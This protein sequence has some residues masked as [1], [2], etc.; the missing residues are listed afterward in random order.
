MTLTQAGDAAFVETPDL[1]DLIGHEAAW[2]DL[3]ARAA[4]PNVF[5][6]PDFLLPALARL[7][8]RGLAIVFVWS[9]AMRARL[10]GLGAIERP[11]LSLGLARV[12]RSEQAALAALLV[13]RE[14]AEDALAALLAWTAARGAAGLRLPFL[15]TEGPTAQAAA[16]LAARRSLPLVTLETRRRAVLRAGEGAD[17]AAGLDKR[18]RKEWARQRRRL[19]ER[20]R[21]ETRSLGAAA[22]AEAFLAVENRGWKGARGTALARV[23]AH[24]AFANDMLARFAAQGALRAVA[25]ML[26]DAPIAVGLALRTGARG[27][28]W[29]TAYDE[30]F[31]EYSPGLLLTLDLSRSL[32]RE[33][34]LTLVDSCAAPNHPMID[35]LWRARLELADFA[36]AVRPETAGR[37][38][39]ALAAGWLRERARARLKAVFNRFLRRKAS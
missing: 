31:A 9:D 36:L 39:R 38:A 18:R 30:R 12:W 6:E 37:F 5:A 26:D 3:A 11:R 28:Y 8:P 10:I 21:L 33:E 1:H 4:E 14:A 22:G 27:F 20:G 23:E 25:L 2:R 34:G 35:H 15:E 32:E 13:D 19:G 16:A 7:A 17:F 24:A 29:K